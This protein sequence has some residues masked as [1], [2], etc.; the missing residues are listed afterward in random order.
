M[1][2]WHK[3]LIL[4]FLLTGLSPNM[5]ENLRFRIYDIYRR[6]IVPWKSLFGR[7]GLIEQVNP[8]ETHRCIKRLVIVNVGCF[9]IRLTAI[10]IFRQPGLVDELICDDLGHFNTV[11]GFVWEHLP[12]ENCLFRVELHSVKWIVFS[13]PH[14]HKFL[15]VWWDCFSNYS[16]KTVQS[17]V[18]VVCTT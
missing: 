2:S 3:S 13:L 1:D 14:A 4:E 15:V 9:K 17:W 5:L 10:L 11:I 7:L 6:P 18:S 8:G 12:L 16:P